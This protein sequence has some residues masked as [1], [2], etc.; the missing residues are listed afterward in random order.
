MLELLLSVKDHIHAGT[1]RLHALV[2]FVLDEAV[3]KLLKWLL[4]DLVLVK[5]LVNALGVAVQ[6]ETELAV[7]MAPR[8]VVAV[9][10]LRHGVVHVGEDFVWDCALGVLVEI[11]CDFGGIARHSDG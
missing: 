2:P 8:L 11:R 5:R 3:M 10:G 1:G 7:G 4:A 6:L 9:F